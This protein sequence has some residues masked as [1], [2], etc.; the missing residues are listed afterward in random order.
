ML[1]RFVVGFG[2]GC[3]A[4]LLFVVS[5]QTSALA[6]AL[7]YL[8]P[9]P[10]MIATLGWGFDAG[11]IAA[12]VSVTALAL[13]AEPL[14]AMAFAA[15]VAGP[16]WGVA[17]FAIFPVARYFGARKPDAPLYPSV[18]AV[19]LLAALIG[20]L[21]SAAVL[22]TIIVAYGGY[23]EGARQVATTVAALVA[24][25]F[26]GA[27]DGVSAR[28]FADT[29]VRFGPA[30]IAAS[31]LLTL[32]VNLYG[33]ARSTQL[34]NCLPRSWPDLPT[35]LNLPWPLGVV[36]PACLAGAYALPP[37]AAQYFSIVAGGLGGA[38]IL[39]GLTVAHA[40]SRGLKMRPLMLV[41]LYACCV[42]RAKYTLPVLAGIG[43]VDLFLRLRSRPALIPAPT[44]TG[45]K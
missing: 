3:A 4:A 36:F 31:T 18:G 44:P 28:E 19:V 42:L 27:P 45:H 9:L 6:I 39:Q 32:C 35:S 10:I 37:P 22:T 43:L 12:T 33:A 24:D 16:A 41:A 14:S 5:A 15:S 2:A 8:A 23:R 29:L 20:I 30:A 34:S 13:L 40:L 7:A 25:A 1:H 21:A 17:A 11:A 38:L 26:E